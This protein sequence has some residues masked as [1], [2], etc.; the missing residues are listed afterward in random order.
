MSLLKDHEGDFWIGTYM[1]LIYFDREAETFKWF[2]DIYSDSSD[3]D[4]VRI[5]SI[6]EDLEKNLW[7][8]TFGSGLRLFDQK[9]NKLVQFKND[10]QPGSISGN[11][12]SDIHTDRKGNVWIAT[13]Y[14]GLNL[15]EKATGKFVQF[16]HDPKDINSI[17]KNAFPS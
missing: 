1:G 9:N 2:K 16:Q 15:Y 12:I 13:F 6:N 4:N 11:F 5:H 3:L 8:G 17:S 7:I 14:N 10:G